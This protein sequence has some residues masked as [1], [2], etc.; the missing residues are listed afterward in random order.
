MSNV[1]VSKGLC[2]YP[3]E[4]GDGQ[5]AFSL[6]EIV[7][8][9]V[10]LGV[11]SA[12]AIA[13]YSGD[14]NE[15]SRAMEEYKAAV[16][17]A[18]SRSLSSGAVWGVENSGGRYRVYSVQSGAKVYVTPL[19]M[20]GDANHWVSLPSGFS[21]GT[22]VISFDPWGVPYMDD[23]ATT[24]QSTDR[25]ITISGSSTLSVIIVRFTGFMA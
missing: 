15:V 19:G 13:R 3:Q 1:H 8:V 7:A 21:L 14:P 18:Q 10:I 2:M 6:I 25:T 22:G 9:L 11:L 17:Y 5:Q 16:R 20:E 24:V 4:N 23:W 12:I